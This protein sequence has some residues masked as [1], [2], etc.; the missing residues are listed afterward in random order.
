MS[1]QP[2][3]SIGVIVGSANPVKINAVKAVLSRLHPHH[4][5]IVISYKADPGIQDWKSKHAIGQPFGI[6][7]TA[8]GAINRTRDCWNHQSK[9][10]L[11]SHEKNM[12][13]VLKTDY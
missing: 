12:P 2:V 13:C 4:N 10:F 7:Q 6:S 5:I 1:I 3:S 8:E 11:E 9:L